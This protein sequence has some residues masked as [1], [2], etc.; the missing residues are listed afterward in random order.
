MFNNNSK[1]DF[2]LAQGIQ[3]EK[4][5]ASLLGLSKDKFECKAEK[6]LWQEKGNL[7]IEIECYGKKSGISITEAKYWVHSFFKEN[8]LVGITI[9]EVEKLKTII[10]NNN[11]RTVMGGDNGA[12]KLVLIPMSDYL[13]QWRYL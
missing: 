8:K 3:D 7:A 12:S 9:L 2:D 6:N 1:F 13:N 11:Y 4:T 5:I 10:A